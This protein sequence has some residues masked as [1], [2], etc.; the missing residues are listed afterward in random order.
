MRLLAI[1]RTNDALFKNIFGVEE[2][3]HITLDLINSFFEYEGTETLADF[4]F[5]DRELDPEREDGKRSLL[6]IA[7]FTSTG[8][9]VNLELQV[10]PDWFMGKRTMF[11]WSILYRWLS[12]GDNYS[13]LKRTVMLNILDFNFFPLEKCPDYHNC[14]GIYN[15][16]NHYQLTKDL[17]LHFIELPKL[18][19]DLAKDRNLTAAEIEKMQRLEK[20]ARYF[21]RHTKLE[22]LEAIAMGVPA[23]QEAI[24]AE[25]Y[26]HD[27]G[28][29]W[30]YEQAELATKN[31][32]SEIE[33]ATMIGLERGR[34]EGIA[35][36][37][38][39]GI[40]EG[41]AE[42]IAEGREEMQVDSALTLLKIG[43][44][45]EIISESS[46][47]SVARIEELAKEHGYTVNYDK[48]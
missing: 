32:A 15:S 26:F 40:A 42:G 1:N 27:F 20:W 11:Y 7:G 45:V 14:F 10:A 8:T 29:W 9:R 35:E 2:R 39:E 28:E 38:V 30:R 33:T 44:N 18:R 5:M 21:S 6:D 36:G 34:A 13:N 12:R 24:K 23:M 41:R 3:K 48:Y 43:I 31:R 19:L 25:N 4:N 22:D 16:K 17:E 37:R 46:R 47:L